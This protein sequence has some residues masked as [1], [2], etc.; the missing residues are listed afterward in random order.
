MAPPI[1]PK[2]LK[3]V[4]AMCR[5]VGIDQAI[6]KNGLKNCDSVRRNLRKHVQNRQ[7]PAACSST[8]S[9]PSST[10]VDLSSDATVLCDFAAKA[11]AAAETSAA[12]AWERGL[13]LFPT[14]PM[15]SGYNQY[16][17]ALYGRFKC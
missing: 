1:D 12:A 7:A 2:V 4:D 14:Y 3:A 17:D 6:Q 15:G 16:M 11:A 9:S 8:I 10:A 13:Y 5:G